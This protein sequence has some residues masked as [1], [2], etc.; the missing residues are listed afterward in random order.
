MR[1]LFGM[2][3]G[4]LRLVAVVFVSDTWSTEPSAVTGTTV[5]R[6]MVNWDVVADDLRIL[7]QHV[8]EAWTSL[9]RRVMG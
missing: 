8:R 7:R 5:H 6:K 4:A 3:L 2:I 9:S 1:V